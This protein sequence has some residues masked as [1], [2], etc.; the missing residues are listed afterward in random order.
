MHRHSASVCLFSL[1]LVVVANG[2]LSATE[3][4]DHFFRGFYLQQ[5]G[6]T[7]AALAEY[8]QALEAPGNSAVRTQVLEQLDTITEDI[9]AADMSRLMPIDSIVYMEISKPGEHLEQIA[10][11]MGLS[12]RKQNAEERVAHQRAVD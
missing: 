6:E 4:E 11:T 8:K 10:R 9:L 3:A 2:S 1:I 12:G 7:K 5:Q